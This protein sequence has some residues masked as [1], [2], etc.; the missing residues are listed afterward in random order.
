[1]IKFLR[2]EFYPTTHNSH[3]RQTSMP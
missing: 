3:N 1:V 2:K